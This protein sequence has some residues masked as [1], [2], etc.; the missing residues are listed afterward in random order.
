MREADGTFHTNSYFCTYCG[1]ITLGC[2]HDILMLAHSM[3][4]KV[5]GATLSV[6][7]L[8]L[9]LGGNTTVAKYK[10]TV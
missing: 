6:L 9:F 2:I 3:V 4:N 5:H 1:I 8:G 10:A 7:P